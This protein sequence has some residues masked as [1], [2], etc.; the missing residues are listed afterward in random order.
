MCNTG[1][2]FYPLRSTWPRSVSVSQR[3][4]RI[5]VS[6]F[7]PPKAMGIVTIYYAS[8]PNSHLLRGTTI[9]FGLPYFTI[10]VGLNVILTLMISVRLILHC[11]N[12]QG[13]MGST[14][15]G[16]SLYRTIIAMLI[17]SSALY[18]IASLL[19]IGPYATSNSASDIFLPILAE[20]Q[21]GIFV[22]SVRNTII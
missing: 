16:S 8:Q 9:N 15:G 3:K 2:S 17:E 21:V 18:A 13:S 7:H 12:I 1:S 5:S 4:K 11:R 6:E 14:P 10:S 20:V 19:F 22:N